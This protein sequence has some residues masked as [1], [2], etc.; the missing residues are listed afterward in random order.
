MLDDAINANFIN[1]EC[2]KMYPSFNKADD[3]LNYIEN[4][5]EMD[6]SKMKIQKEK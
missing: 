3:V 4:Y 1:A 6:L 2:K 5:K